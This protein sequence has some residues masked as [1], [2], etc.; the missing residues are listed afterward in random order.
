M[1][2]VKKLSFEIGDIWL[3]SDGEA[4]T[5]LCFEGSKDFEKYFKGGKEKN[6]PI[7]E[8]TEKWL[9]IYFSGKQP[10]F[11]PKIRFENLSKFQ[12]EVTDELMKIPFGKTVTYGEIANQLAKKHGI[13]KMSAQA[14]GRAVGA[15][16]ICII[17]PCHRVV[18]AKG[19]LTGYDGGIKNKIALLKVEGNDMSKFFVP[20]KKEDK[21]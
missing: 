6:L 15:N 9:K 10:D 17:V 7:F 13:K 14:V 20:A 2:Y 21:I 18:G 11:V 3:A 16:K 19:N 1:F 4:L 8:E 5:A 12:S